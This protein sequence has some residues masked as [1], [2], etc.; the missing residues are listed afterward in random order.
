M[1]HGTQ[2][3]YN[4]AYYA[5]RGQSGSRIAFW[6]YYRLAARFVKRGS[7]LDYGC[8]GGRLLKYFNT[9]DYET[10]GYDT[11]QDALEMAKENTVS[12]HLYGGRDGLA[13]KSF[14]LICAI[15]V[16]E[17]IEEP[18]ETLQFIRTLLNPRGI[19][20]YVVPNISGIGHTLKKNNWI[21]YGDPAHV[22]LYPA[23][24]WIGLTEKAGFKL[25][26]TGTDGLW[27]VPYID[28][29][30]LFIQRIIFYPAPA[31]QVMAGRLILPSRW[32]ESLIAIAQRC[33]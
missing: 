8:G 28:G 12:G 33:E 14:D 29:I 24:K 19:L 10:Y 32:G 16:L 15:H 1:A 21:G 22:S 23:A 31:F 26:S 5:A 6:F 20:M 25:L 7:V 2:V 9:K 13:G 3:A 17:H 4:R 27:D 18:F 11:S 30:P